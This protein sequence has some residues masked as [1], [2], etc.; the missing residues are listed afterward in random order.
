MIDPAEAS[1]TT[2]LRP[3]AGRRSA[4][5]NSEVD[6]DAFDPEIYRDHNYRELR[7]DDHQIMVRMREHFAEAKLTN[8]Q[9]VDVGPGPN[10]YPALA[11]L[12]FC[13]TLDLLE[14]S[15]PNVSYLRTQVA[16]FDESWDDFWA[17][18]R[19]NA[20]HAAVHDPRA[21]LR[22]VATITQSSI[23]G[24]PEQ[25]WDL[26][27]MFFV[28]CSLSTDIEEF[29]LAT[30]RFVRSLKPG[31]PFAAAFMEGS[32]GYSV[33]T[34]RFPAVRIRQEDVAQSLAPV[35]YHDVLIER[36]SSGDAPLRDGYSGMILALGKAAGLT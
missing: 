16:Y 15:R 24:M 8:A 29:H 17:V 13:R 2:A 6:W 28:A 25:R 32:L 30:R 33:G 19:I 36:I 18:F 9:G 5:L 11:M 23:F 35:A 7:G 21:R 31:A 14:L 34:K 10:L 20:A 22:E 1:I 26:G 3:P 4:H 27:T 12:P